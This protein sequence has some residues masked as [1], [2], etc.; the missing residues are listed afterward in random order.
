VIGLASGP[1]METADDSPG[2]DDV[3]DAALRAG[4]VG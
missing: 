2:A 4:S 3:G 1:A